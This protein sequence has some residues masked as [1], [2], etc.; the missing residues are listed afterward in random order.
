M[1]ETPKEVVRIG[2]ATARI[3]RVGPDLVDYIDDTGREQ[4]IDLQECAVGWAALHDSHKR[5]FIALPGVS[6]RTAVDWNARCV[7]MRSTQTHAPWA[8][9]RN[10]RSTRFIFTT[11][12]ALYKDLLTPMQRA[13]WH[14][15]DTD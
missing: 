14:T 3:V 12:E 11:Y 8:Q 15:F 1:L 10:A 2:T 4:F 13:G 9:F 6:E 5:E 7:G